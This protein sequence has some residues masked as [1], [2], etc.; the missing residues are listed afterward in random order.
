MRVGSGHISV[1]VPDTFEDVTSYV[2]QER[3]FDPDK[4]VPPDRL[5]V[6]FEPLPEHVPPAHVISHLR[7]NLER[8]A[9]GTASFTPGKARAGAL[10]AAPLRVDVSG[11]PATMF[12]AALRWPGARIARVQYESSRAD[13]AAVF[14]G[15]V[16]SVRS[17][18]VRAAPRP[19]MVRRRAGLLW[20]EMPVAHA[21][22]SSYSFSADGGR[23][24]LFVEDEPGPAGEEPDFEG[25]VDHGVFDSIEIEPLN[26][27]SFAA[28]RRPI[29]ERSWRADRIGEE[30][31]YLGST[32]FRVAWVSLSEGAA[33]R[34]WMIERERPELG[35]ACWADIVATI[36][37]TAESP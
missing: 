3:P 21:P 9:G 17:I 16:A 8:S 1:D 32:W 14:E 25:W 13:A 12:V 36:R 19:G 6:A 22:L 26:E 30:G 11:S 35:D 4:G 34:V 37:R 20:L 23:A 24:R 31:D 27:G 15:V 5:T 28:D 33:A 10:D 7:R 2:F 18:G 29:E